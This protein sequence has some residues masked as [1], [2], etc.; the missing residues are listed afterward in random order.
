LYKEKWRNRDIKKYDSIVQKQFDPIYRAIMIFFE[1]GKW[2][3]TLLNLHLYILVVV[4][5]F[6]KGLQYQLNKSK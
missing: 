2:K 6:L 5:T 4:I 3:Q 1:N